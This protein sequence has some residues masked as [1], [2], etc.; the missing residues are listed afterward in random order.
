MNSDHRNVPI[1]PASWP[2][3]AVVDLDNL[4]DPGFWIEEHIPDPAEILFR[5][6]SADEDVAS[7]LAYNYIK[8]ASELSFPL[9]SDFDATPEEMEQMVKDDFLGFIREWRRLTL[10]EQIEEVANSEPAAVQTQ[11]KLRT[12]DLLSEFGF[13]QA[14]GISPGAP[15]RLTFDFGNFK[16]SAICAMNMRSADV[17]MFSGVMATSRTLAEVDFELPRE[18][19]SAEQCAAWIAWNLDQSAGDSGFRPTK[20]TKWLSV[21]REHRNQLPWIMESM[22]YE[23]RPHCFLPRDWARMVLKTLRTA[24][25]K[26][27]GDAD[28]LFHFDGEAL[29]IRCGEESIAAAATGKA[30]TECYVLKARELGELPNRLTRLQVTVSIWQGFLEIANRRY[31]DVRSEKISS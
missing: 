25:E 20:E 1:W 18:M 17:V 3:M 27:S 19:D 30:W 11:P 15:P 10:A 4:G 24:L 7:E 8:S 6:P 28:V 22:A 9:P 2:G 26:V 14:R 12:W 13:T 31:K 5:D 16:L 23:G 21:G 29:K